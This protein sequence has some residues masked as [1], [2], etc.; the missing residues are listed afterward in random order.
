M[1]NLKVLEAKAL[2]GEDIVLMIN[3]R[4]VKTY[5]YPSFGQRMM[6]RFVGFFVGKKRSAAFF[7]DGDHLFFPPGDWDVNAIPLEKIARYKKMENLWRH[8]DNFRQSLSYKIAVA[9]MFVGRFFG[10]GMVYKKTPIKTFAEL[11]DL[12]KHHLLNILYSLKNEG[13]RMDIE[14]DMP[15]VSIG[16]EGQIIKSKRGRH[17]FIAAK[18]VGLEKMPVVVSHIHPLWFEKVVN[19]SGS[20]TRELGA[21]L[22]KLAV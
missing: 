8:R 18:I 20:E 11:E 22:R 1:K 19:E 17:R 10:K 14:Q 5:G 7:P 2:L 9:K 6:V 15:E 12:L 3:P 21:A 13:Y 4:V 16:R